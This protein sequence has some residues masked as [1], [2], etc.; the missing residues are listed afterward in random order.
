MK[1][2][3]WLMP[4]SMQICPQGAVRSKQLKQELIACSVHPIKRAF[5]KN[6]FSTASLW[7]SW[8]LAHLKC[9]S[10]SPSNCSCELW[11]KKIN[12]KEASKQAAQVL[13]TIVKAILKFL[14][15][16][17]VVGCRDLCASL[18]CFTA[19][20]DTSTNWFLLHFG[21][22]HPSYCQPKYS[23]LF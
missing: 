17:T 12:K 16:D 6:N 4:N 23:R 13:V 18:D 7:V 11:C 14:Q 8:V 9:K 2:E 1:D 21:W 22:K 20:E 10:T 19:T 5:G 3:T 15:S